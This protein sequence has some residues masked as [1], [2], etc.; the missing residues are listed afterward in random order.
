[1]KL[2]ADPGVILKATPPR[3]TKWLF[4]RDDLSVENLLARL[5]QTPRKKGCARLRSCGS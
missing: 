3:A 4:H 5:L 1:M 2:D